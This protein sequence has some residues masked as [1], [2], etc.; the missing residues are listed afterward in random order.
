MGFDKSILHLPWY[1]LYFLSYLQ[2]SSQV[3]SLMSKTF[4][5]LFLK[6][7][8]REFLRE[9]LNCDTCQLFF[10][11]EGHNFEVETEAYIKLRFSSSMKPCSFTKTRSFSLVLSQRLVLSELILNQEASLVLW[12]PVSGRLILSQ[13][14][15]HSERRTYIEPGSIFG[16]SAPFYDHFAL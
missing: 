12:F 11:S 5:Q 3:M 2:R 10:C 9:F 16:A 6:R 15:L 8:L 1:K 4:K 14:H 13:R 7:E